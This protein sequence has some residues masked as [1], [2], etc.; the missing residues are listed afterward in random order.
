MH[1]IH[2]L[3]TE[4]LFYGQVDYVDITYFQST[5][6]VFLLVN[7][8]YNFYTVP[9]C[10]R[11]NRWYVFKCTAMSFVNTATIATGEDEDASE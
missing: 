4:L 10:V 8:V 5:Y 3:G 11:W 6:I 9:T 7:A 1:I 2:V